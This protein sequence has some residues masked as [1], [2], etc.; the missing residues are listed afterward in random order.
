MADSYADSDGK[1]WPPSILKKVGHTKYV[2]LLHKEDFIRNI[3]TSNVFWV[4]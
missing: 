4:R 2:G 3:I 1:G